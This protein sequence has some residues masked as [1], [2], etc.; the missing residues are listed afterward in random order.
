MVFDIIIVRL[1]HN[2]IL[3]EGRYNRCKIICQYIWI[4]IVGYIFTNIAQTHKAQTCEVIY[5]QVSDKYLKF[6]L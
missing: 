2:K 5:E 1:Y 3:H 6:K 4:Y